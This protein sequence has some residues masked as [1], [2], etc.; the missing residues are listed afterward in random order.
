MLKLWRLDTTVTIIEVGFNMFLFE[1]ATEGA[2]EKVWD[3]QPWSFDQSLLCFKYFDGLTPPSIM[4]FTQTYIW[5]QVHNLPFGCM[6][7]NIGVQLGSAIG[8]IYHVEAD[9]R[10]T[11]WG[12]FL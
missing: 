6:N 9:D 10:G 3:G 8:P 12:R 2:L 5:V 7:T 11:S 1:F 4:V